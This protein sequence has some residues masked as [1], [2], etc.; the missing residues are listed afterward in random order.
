TDLLVGYS[1]ARLEPKDDIVHVMCQR[2]AL[3]VVGLRIDRI[4]RF[5]KKE[6]RIDRFTGASSD[7][8]ILCHAHNFIQTCRSRIAVAE[9]LADRVVLLK[10]SFDKGLIHYRHVLRICRSEE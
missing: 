4:L 2:I 1:C 7:A 8:S 10:E 6:K 9:E 3:R 5:G